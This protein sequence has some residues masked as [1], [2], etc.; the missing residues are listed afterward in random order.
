MI[1]D[2][3]P[4]VQPPAPSEVFDDDIE[5]EKTAKKKTTTFDIPNNNPPS[6][7][8]NTPDKGNKNPEKIPEIEVMTLKDPEITPN[9]N[10]TMTQR[11]IE[12]ATAAVIVNH[13]ITTP[14]TLQLRPSKGSTNLNVLKA[15]KNIFSAMK[16]IDPTLKLITFQNE[17]IDTTDQFPSSALEYTNKFKNFHKDPKTSRVY[18][19]HKI[20]SAIPLGEIKYGNRQQL[21]NIF[22]TLV[23]N[24]AFLNLNK[25][26]THKEHSIGFFTNINPKVTLR[27]NFRNEI[28][29][30]LMWID[31]DDEESAPMVHQIKDS[32]GKLTGKQK[33]IIPAFDLYSKEVGDGNGNERVTTFAYEIRTSPDNAN[34]LK[35]LLC[36]ISNE[37]NSKLRFIPYGIQSLSKQG[38]MRNII[39]QH[40]LFLQNMAI[41]PIV[42][43]SNAEKEQVKKLF[44][45]SLYFSGFEPTR[46]IAEGMYLLVTNKSVINKAQ[47]EADNLLQKFCGQRQALPN[48]KI[49]ERKKRPLIHNQVSSYAAALSQNTSQTPSQSMIY[50]P[51]SYKRPISISFTPEAS[52]PN[53][54]W[55]LPT[56]QFSK[57]PNF[58][59]PTFQ[60]PP[61]QKRKVQTENSSIVTA[62]TTD[63]TNYQLT[64]SSWKEELEELTQESKS[65]M[66]TMIKD[67]NLTMTTTI[68]ESVNETLKD[69]QTTLMK[70]C[71]EM[72]AKQM[73]IINL[74]M[75]NTIKATLAEQIVTPQLIPSPQQQDTRTQPNILPYRSP[76]TPPNTQPSHPSPEE[77]LNSTILNQYMK[78]NPKRKLSNP[79]DPEEVETNIEAMPHPDTIMEDQENL[80]QTETRTSAR[81][82]KSSTKENKKKSPVYSKQTLSRLGRARK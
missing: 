33:I 14:V 32:S 49:P 77:Q 53:K 2:D 48:D 38:T 71:E 17:I 37:G 56:S 65:T 76:T 74:N 81:P 42:N 31:L 58:N 10:D 11:T 9:A 68:N 75:I 8:N 72:I 41:V 21:S 57:S 63:S 73:S 18:I 44:E 69:F 70:T 64:T 34:M 7:K 35:N 19:S 25:F 27:D 66:E 51:P 59:P 50:S 36:K 39:L 6:E 20:E 30:E 78:I 52:F 61:S 12:V 80:N 1:P 46:K 82:S 62:T 28:Q 22:D 67:N 60:P 26:S 16:L 13:R 3:E 47:N 5:N 55:T 40:N 24:N 45:S 23:S 43:I 29:N 54:P 79:P 4:T 15:H